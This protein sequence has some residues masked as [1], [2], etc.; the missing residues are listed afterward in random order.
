MKIN[1]LPHKS[2]TVTVIPTTI[3]EANNT[4]MVCFNLN[5]VDYSLEEAVAI[6]GFCGY[7]HAVNGA[8]SMGPSAVRYDRKRRP[9]QLVAVVF[10]K[11][12]LTKEEPDHA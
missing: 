11:I 1:D 2:A 7:V 3:V 10:T 6:E 4:R 5:H 9:T 12:K 8:Y